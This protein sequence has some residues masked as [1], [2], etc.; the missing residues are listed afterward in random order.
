MKLMYIASLDFYSKPNPS[1]HL[2]TSMLEDILASNI[3]VDL[4]G[5]KEEGLD[6]HIPD[7]LINNKAFSY[8]LVSIPKVKKSSFIKRYL[9]GIKYSLRIGQLIKEKINSCDLIFVQSSPTVLYTIL[10]VRKYCGKKKIIYNVQDMFPGSSIASGIMPK[11]WMQQIFYFLQKIAYR[12][13]DCIVA[14]SEDMKRK[15]VEQGV[16]SN[17]IEVIVNWFDDRTIHE[18]KWEEN[19]FVKKYNMSKDI[20][21]VQYA[22]T[23]GYVFDYKIVLDVA[24][25]L[26]N[27]KDIIFQMI[28]EGSQKKKFMEESKKRGLDN[29][30]FLPLEPQEMVSDVYSSCSI[31]FIPL[32]KGIIG[33]SV[34]SKA[35]LLMA[36]KKTIV[37]SS[38]KESVYF[39]N[40]NKF[41]VGIAKSVDD[42][43]GVVNSIILLRENKKVCDFLATNAYEYG[44]KI[45]SRSY[46]M[47]KY[48]EL[49][50]KIISKNE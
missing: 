41:N 21:Y 6:K 8:S 40:F 14:I 44:K 22:G 47:K 45:Y 12:K 2:M 5:C 18:V 3:D 35:G 46:N 31:C 24:Q 39:E 48:I 11:K 50:E 17:K 7:S 9:E 13:S 27:R 43:E 28:G 19:R 25:K 49:F 26:K 38:D 30:L 36:C 33:N 23:M 10:Q 1:F 20:F 32:K 37:T 16:P 42:V 34:P 29:I 15:L 4:I